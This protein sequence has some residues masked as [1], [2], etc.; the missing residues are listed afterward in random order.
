MFQTFQKLKLNH[1]C[2]FG[3]DHQLRPDQRN[4]DADDRD[5][6]HHAR[7]VHHGCGHYGNGH[8]GFGLRAYEYLVQ[9]PD[10]HVVCL[11]PCWKQS[12]TAQE[13]LKLQL[14]ICEK[15]FPWLTLLPTYV[16]Y[17]K[18]PAIAK[19]YSRFA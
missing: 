10:V 18:T 13:G 3:D 17:E 2:D 7:H 16:R 19:K 14:S 8:H 4:A 6:A 15:I 5:E 11:P 9:T 12:A 1:L